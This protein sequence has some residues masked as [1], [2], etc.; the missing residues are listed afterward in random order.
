[1]LTSMASRTPDRRERLVR[2]TRHCDGNTR[3]SRDGGK[4]EHRAVILIGSAEKV[5]DGETN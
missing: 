1:M 4:S 3:V 2:E 5:T